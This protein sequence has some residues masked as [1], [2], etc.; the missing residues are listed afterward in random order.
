[1]NDMLHPPFPIPDIPASNSDLADLFPEFVRSWIDE[2]T[3]FVLS[4]A[5][6]GNREELY[7]LGHTI[8]GS[9]MQFGLDAHALIGIQLMTF[10]DRN[11]W[12]SALAYL[13][14]LLQML[15]SLQVQLDLPHL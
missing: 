6:R 10:A 9:F 7:R 12:P 5:Q 13:D 2:I 3:A 1:M 15:R 11:D 14:A 8:K 4:D